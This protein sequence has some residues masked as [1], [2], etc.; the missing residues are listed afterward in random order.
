M[1][2]SNEEKTSFITGDGTYCYR[3]MPFRLKNARATYQRLMNRIFK[4]QIGRNVKVYVH[5]MVVKSQTFQQ[6]LTD[7]EEVFGVL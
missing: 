2:R 4:D 3:T 6:H 7:L 1:D 5:D